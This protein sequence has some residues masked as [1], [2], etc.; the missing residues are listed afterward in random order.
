M[1]DDERLSLL[2]ADLQNPPA[3]N[4][5]YLNHLLAVAEERIQAEGIRLSESVSDEN[6]RIMYA[7]Y[8]YRKRAAPETAMPRMLRYALNQALFHRKGEVSGA[9]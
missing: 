1:S 9:T 5:A 2:K 6:L 8:L 4:D 3:A 7:A